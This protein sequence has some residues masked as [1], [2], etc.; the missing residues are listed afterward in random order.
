MVVWEDGGG[1]SAS[2]PITE[3]SAGGRQDAKVAKLSLDEELVAQFRLGPL[4]CLF[5]RCGLGGLGA[6]AA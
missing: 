5:I 3:A 6:L 2:Y 4:C 1:D